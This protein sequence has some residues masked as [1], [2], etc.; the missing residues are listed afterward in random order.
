MKPS[1][2]K[3]KGFFLIKYYMKFVVSEVLPLKF[4]C[5]IVFVGLYMLTV[6]SNHERE[7]H[8]VRMAERTRVKKYKAINS[9]LT[10][11]SQFSNPKFFF[12]FPSALGSHSN[13]LEFSSLLAFNILYTKKKNIFFCFIVGCRVSFHS[14]PKILLRNN[15]FSS[16]C[17]LLWQLSFSD[18]WNSLSLSFSHLTSFFYAVLDGSMLNSLFLGCCNPLLLLKKEKSLIEGSG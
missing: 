3:Y 6:D 16:Y 18:G 17:H 14:I 5:W 13:V 11:F 9:L 8:V 1:K 15:L 7:L 10:G 12:P 2:Q 4:I